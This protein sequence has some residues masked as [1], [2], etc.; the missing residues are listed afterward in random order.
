[1]A[2]VMEPTRAYVRIGGALK[3]Q[4][5][6]PFDIGMAVMQFCLQAEEEG[7]GTCIIGWFDEGKVRRLLGVPRGPWPGAKAV[8]LLCAGLADRRE[9]I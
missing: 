2:V 8:A 4:D 3:G 1:V 9:G 7:L 5:Y 6:R